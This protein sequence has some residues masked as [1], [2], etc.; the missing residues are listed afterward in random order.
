[1]PH[2]KISDS[3]KAAALK[4]IAEGLTRVEVAERYG[5]SIPTIANWKK[6]AGV[7]K[8]YDGSNRT[9]TAIKRQIMKGW[10]WAYVGK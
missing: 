1:M 4:D 7:V 6:E 2:N 9:L 5:V 8:E 10:N 3:V